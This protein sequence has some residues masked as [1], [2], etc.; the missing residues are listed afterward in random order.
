MERNLRQAGVGKT[1][2]AAFSAG[3]LVGALV[4]GL[5]FLGV[6]GAWPIA[7]AF[8]LITLIMP[9]VRLTPGPANTALSC[10]RCGQTQLTPWF[11]P[12]GPG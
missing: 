6:S 1:S 9:V 10:A 3:C 7:L 2:P 8:A 11:L 12:S 4:V 5:V